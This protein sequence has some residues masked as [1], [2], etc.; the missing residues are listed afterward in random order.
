MLKQVWCCFHNLGEEIEPLSAET[1][2]AKPNHS[3]DT[4]AGFPFPSGGEGT[5]ASVG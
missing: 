2:G 3:T 4:P 5:V 1:S